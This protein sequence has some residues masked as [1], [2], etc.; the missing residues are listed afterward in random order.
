MEKQHSAD[1]DRAY[2][3]LWDIFGNVNAQLQFAETKN[4][5]LVTVNLALVVAIGTML[6]GDDI[7]TSD[8]RT[9]LFV[10]AL[11]LAGSALVSLLSFLPHLGGDIPVGTS[12]RTPA[13]LIYFNDLSDAGLS[14]FIAAVQQATGQVA[15]TTAL[16]TGLGHQIIVN[17]GIARRKF[18]A[19][20]V[21][22]IATVVC[23]TIP[24]VVLAFV[25]VGNGGAFK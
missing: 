6:A 16:H 2:G 18:E 8:V 22:A 7:A 4:G 12:G 19:F 11:G 3:V 15:V 9:W 20:K 21:A 14:E 25:W 10:T 23:S 5:A 13:N 24:S 1:E 17:S